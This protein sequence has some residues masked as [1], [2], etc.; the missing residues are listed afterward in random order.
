V[1]LLTVDEATTSYTAVVRLSPGAS[2]PARKHLR[3][4]EMWMLTGS[5]VIGLVEMNA[6]EYCRAEAGA[7]HPKIT[8]SRGCT[9][10]LRGN[11]NDELLP[12]SR[13]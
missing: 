4:E 10:L 6:G 12:E 7:A 9:F 1:K 13:R 8:S 11:E 2:L 5:A 3:E